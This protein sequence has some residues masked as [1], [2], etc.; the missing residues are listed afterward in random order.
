MSKLKP[1]FQ[2]FGEDGGSVI[3]SCP[4]Q[5]W[6]L[7]NIQWG[8]G[9]RSN[10]KFKNSVRVG[11]LAIYHVQAKSEIYIVWWGRGPVIFSYPGKI[12]NLKCLVRL[13]GQSS[14]HVQTKAEISIFQQ[15]LDGWS[16]YH[17]HAKSQ[18]KIF[19]EGG[20]SVI[21]SC[22]GLI[23]SLKIFSEGWGSRS[24]LKFKNFSEGWRVGHLTMSRPNLK[25]I[26]FG[27]VGGQSSFHIQVKS[28]I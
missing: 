13:G 23:W 26:L 25:F 27:E 18:I 10:L 15:R 2:I 16:S 17:T 28:E 6:S 24:N 21:F 5:I 14:F 3:F 11:G 19:G 9:S 22:P 12:W 8:L 7:K 4:G 20:G 1:K